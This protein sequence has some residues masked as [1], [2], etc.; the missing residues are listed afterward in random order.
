MKR[1]PDGKST[2]YTH[3]PTQK[4]KT[5]QEI[6]DL[7]HIHSHIL[8]IKAKKLLIFLKNPFLI[9]C[10][11]LTNKTLFSHSK[12]EKASICGMGLTLISVYLLLKFSLFAMFLETEIVR[13]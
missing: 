5:L 13:L 2:I 6:H 10:I 9:F 12:A 11:F 1:K 7:V 8:K 3:L 4:V